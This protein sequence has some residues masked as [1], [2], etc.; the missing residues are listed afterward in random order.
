MIQRM[1][2][3]TWRGVTR[4]E[5]ADAYSAYLAETG[6]REYR[7]TPGNVTALLLR[8]ELGE[9]TEFVTFSLWESLDAVRGFA[10]DDPD[11]AVFY[12]EDD[13]YLVDRDLFVTHY[14]VAQGP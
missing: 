8:R 13:R 7:T 10:G 12:P 2:A 14:E 11:R 3:R 6:M 9:T 5:D 4:S 1:I